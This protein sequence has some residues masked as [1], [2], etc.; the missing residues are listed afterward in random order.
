LYRYTAGQPLEWHAT[1]DPTV[2]VVVDLRPSTMLALADK[3]GRYKARIQLT[4]SL[5][6][7]GCNP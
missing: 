3:V 2:Q 1:F 5:K 4:H 6:P 7:P